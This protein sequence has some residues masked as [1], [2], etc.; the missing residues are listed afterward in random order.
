M[1]ES[2]PRLQHSTHPPPAAPRF[3]QGLR[4]WF[5][6]GCVCASPHSAQGRA[7]CVAGRQ[8]GPWDICPRPANPPGLGRG[9]QLVL[10]PHGWLSQD[11]V[12]SGPG[13]GQLACWQQRHPPLT[14]TPSSTRAAGEDGLRVRLVRPPGGVADPD[15]ANPLHLHGPG[16]RG[17]HGLLTEGHPDGHQVPPDLQSVSHPGPDL[18][19]VMRHLHQGSPPTRQAPQPPHA[20]QPHVCQGDTSSGGP[21][22]PCSAASWGQRGGKGLTAQPMAPERKLRLKWF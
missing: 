21:G 12:T 13:G 9:W 16:P 22:K 19:P 14:D 2:H 5:P 8:C 17:H 18:C 10:H 6:E 3:P 20:S 4:V 7:A 11:Q 15:A 1:L